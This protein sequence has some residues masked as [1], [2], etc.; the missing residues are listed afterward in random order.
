MTRSG[1]SI[2]FLLGLAIVARVPARAQ[3]FDPEIPRTWDPEEIADFELPLATPEMSPR[4]VS[5]DY[6]YALPVRPIHR[7]YPI[8]HPDHEPPGYWRQLQEAKPEVAFD[9]ARLDS[10]ADWIEAGKVV[11]AAPIAFDRPVLSVAMLRD[12]GWWQAVDPPL[13]RL[14]GRSSTAPASPSCVA[15]TAASTKSSAS[16]VGCTARDSVSW[17]CRR[18]RGATAC[19]RRTPRPP[20]SSGASTPS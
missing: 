12:R 9:T 4:H 1:F 14:R 13:K 7:S 15:P 16:C 11:F 5:A 3:T 8:Y 20:P 6:Y 19:A 10:E 2:A 18:T 17:C